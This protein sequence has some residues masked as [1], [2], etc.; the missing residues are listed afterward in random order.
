M[1]DPQRW[2]YVRLIDRDGHSIRN[3]LYHKP[4]EPAAYIIWKDG[5]KTY[6][7]NGHTGQIPYEDDDSHEVMQSI[8]TE[9]TQGGTILIKNANYEVNDDLDVDGRSKLEI[10]GEGEGTIL[11]Y[12]GTGACIKNSDNPSA[13]LEGFKL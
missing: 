12:K 4:E 3:D 9:L 13:Q 7:K 5:D 1:L 10:I 11:T 8:V 2:E 6:A